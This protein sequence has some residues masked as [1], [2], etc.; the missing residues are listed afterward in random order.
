MAIYK[1]FSEQSALGLPTGSS[2]PLCDFAIGTAEDGD[3]RISGADV[4]G[5]RP[6]A[7]A[8][9]AVCE[10]FVDDAASG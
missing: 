3:G 7:E 1:G 2:V 5:R 4:G 10:R 8:Q 9:E 6:R